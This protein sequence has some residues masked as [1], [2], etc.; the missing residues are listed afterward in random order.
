[1]HVCV[2][3]ASS[4]HVPALY[5][6][7][8]QT[9]GEGMARRG[10]TLVYGG[11]SIGLMG[12]VARAVHAAGGRV[13]GV[14]PQTLLERE[15]GYQEADELIVTGTL[16]ERKQIMDD[17]ADAFV[18]LP[19]GFGTLEELLEIMTLRMLGYH[20]KPIVIVNVGGYFDPL[21]TQFEYIFAQNFAHERYRRL[22]AVKADPEAALTYLERIMP[23]SR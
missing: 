6:E 8:A 4:D 15:V 17:R 19:G 13:V 9:F 23:G 16:R 22:Y 3:C 5:L 1:M 14:I 7:A 21:L 18:A 10:W 12:A 20:N 2:Y 11:G